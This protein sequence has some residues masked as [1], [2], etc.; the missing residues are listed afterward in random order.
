MQ[1]RSLS[2]VFGS[3]RCTVEKN[4]LSEIFHSNVSFSSMEISGF[5][6]ALFFLPFGVLT[7][8]VVALD[9]WGAGAAVSARD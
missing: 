6:S 7:V 2:L 4:H 1:S 9:P 3:R 5:V 8:P